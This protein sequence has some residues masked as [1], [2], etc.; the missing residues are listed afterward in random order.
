MSHAPFRFPPD[1]RT[2]TFVVRQRVI[3]VGKLIENNATPIITE[4]FSHVT[5]QF[6]AAVFWRQDE[7]GTISPHGLPTFNALILGHDQQ[8]AI[9]TRRCGHRQ[10]NT[11]IARSGF[12]QRIA[13]FDFAAFLGMANHGKRRSI[14]HGTRRII[15]FQLGQNN[16]S[17]RLQI[18]PRQ[19]LQAHQR[20]TADVILKSLIHSCLASPRIA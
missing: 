6:H 5:R 14:L 17:T 19:A 11:R 20:R 16:V 7:F 3:G 8:H 13:G 4:F 9:A 12:N 2:G 18:G 15:A 10:R 1:L